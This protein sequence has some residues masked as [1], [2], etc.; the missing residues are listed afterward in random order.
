MDFVA[1]RAEERRNGWRARLRMVLESWG[2]RVFDPWFKPIVRNLGRYGIEDEMT[3][4]ERA[5]WR[6]DEGPVGAAARSAL[7]GA[8]WPVMHV[9]LRMVDLSDFIIA[10]CPTNLY[11]VGTPHEIVVARQE[12]KPV[13][14]VSPPV[15]YPAWHELQSRAAADPEQAGLAARAA[16]EVVAVENVDGRPSQ[17][18]M[19]LVGGESFFDGFG[20]SSNAK[21]FR[22]PDGYLDERE[23]P[24]HPPVRPLLPYLEQIRRGHRPQRWDAKLGGF[25]DNDDWLLLEQRARHPAD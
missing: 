14:L 16:R 24:P 23:A 4:H 15:R 25:R 10:C 8:F 11:S 2:V 19:T 18:Y 6:F 13:L 7:S 17:W 20:W 21:R 9:D 5:S 3:T 12:R 22:W 1:S